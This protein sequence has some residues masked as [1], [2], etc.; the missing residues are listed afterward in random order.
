VLVAEQVLLILVETE[1]PLEQELLRIEAQDL[2]LLETVV[3]MIDQLEEQTVQAQLDQLIAE[4]LDQQL[5]VQEALEVLQLQ[6]EAAERLDLTTLAEVTLE[7]TIL[8]VE[9]LAE[10][11]IL[12]AEALVEVATHQA[13]A[14][15]EV[16]VVQLEALLAVEVALAEVL[17]EETNKKID[18]KLFFQNQLLSLSL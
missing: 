12:Q 14:L 15:A 9:V 4:T 8:Q 10:V 5:E 6:V 18:F 1:E 17:Q 16:V 3:L 2:A 13:E 11:A 7:A